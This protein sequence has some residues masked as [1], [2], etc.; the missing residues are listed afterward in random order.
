ML[1]YNLREKLVA[2]TY[3]GAAAMASAS[4]GLQAKAKQ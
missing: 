4:N 2:Q 1:D 3:D